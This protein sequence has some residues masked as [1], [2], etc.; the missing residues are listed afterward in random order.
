MSSQNRRS[1]RIS[2]RIIGASVGNITASDIQNVS[3]TEKAIIV[4][5]NVKVERAAARASR[6]TRCRSRDI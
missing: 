3:A 2:V 6:A 4:G 5:F 1:E